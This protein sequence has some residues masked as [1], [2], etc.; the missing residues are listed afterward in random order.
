MK[1][2]SYQAVFISVVFIISTYFFS[3]GNFSYFF[4]LVFGL[5]LILVFLKEEIRLFAWIMLSFFGGNLIR[6]YADKFLE[7]LD[8]NAFIVLIASQLLLIIPI[9]SISYV[10][11]AF[12]R[13]I[14]SFLQKPTKRIF[15]IL[16]ITFLL[17]VIAFVITD[18]SQN[19]MQIFLSF[20]LFASIHAALQE[21]I[22]RGILL[23]HII[24][25][26]N[27]Q[28]GIFII[29]LAF[30]IQST[31]LGFS[32]FVFITYSL[33]GILLGFLTIR[34]KS[35]LPAIVVHMLVLFLFFLTGILQI[36]IL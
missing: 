25:I 6:F 24:N 36:H 28:Y 31:L 21:C 15:S 4:L 23:N 27:Q 2:R 26:T 18:E 11:K 29:S 16:F 3:R 19:S 10:I 12:N 32:I 33:L 1:Q 34:T 8:V 17:M 9:L 13:Q 22:W 35:I 5:M 30:G 14:S 20:L 7:V